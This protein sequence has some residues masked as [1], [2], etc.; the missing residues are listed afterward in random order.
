MPSVTYECE[1]LNTS[2]YFTATVEGIDIATT[3]AAALAGSGASAACSSISE[4]AVL[5]VSAYAQSSLG[6]VYA[7]YR[8]D[9]LGVLNVSD[10]AYS[11]ALSSSVGEPSACSVDGL[12]AVQVGQVFAWGFTAVVGFWAIGLG[13]GVVRDM[14]RKF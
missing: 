1:D 11:G 9:G 12:T 7:G 8:I 4:S 10:G 14:I 5:D 13:I 6:G 2:E 3:S